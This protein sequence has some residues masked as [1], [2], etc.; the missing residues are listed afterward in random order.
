MKLFINDYDFLKFIIFLNSSL[1]NCL[2]Q[3]PKSS[4][5]H[6]HP[7]TEVQ[8]NEQKKYQE[9][10]L[11]LAVPSRRNEKAEASKLSSQLHGVS[12]TVFKYISHFS[13]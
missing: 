3:A 13:A 4:L 9:Q 6:L 2:P 12:G 5:C 7:I 10:D 1:F 8:S 11:R